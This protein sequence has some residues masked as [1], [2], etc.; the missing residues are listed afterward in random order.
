MGHGQQGRGR[1]FFS[2]LADE[3]AFWLYLAEYRGVPRVRPFALWLRER[4][5]KEIERTSWRAYTAN[6]LRAIAG[7]EGETWWDIIHPAPVETRTGDEV[8]RAV[9]ERAGLNVTYEGGEAS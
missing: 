4:H 5:R 1:G 9:V 2:V 3:G 6:V 8:A 7:G